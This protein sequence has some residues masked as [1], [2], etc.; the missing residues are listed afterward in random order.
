MPQDL[1]FGASYRATVTGAVCISSANAR[2]L[3]VLSCG[4]ATGAVQLF[5]GVTAT[6]TTNGNPLTGV[7][8]FVTAPNYIDVPAFASGGLTINVGAAASPD[9]TIF[10]SPA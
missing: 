5:A 3:G 8:T 10:W 7:I 9:I 4:T 6:T 1:G 2:I